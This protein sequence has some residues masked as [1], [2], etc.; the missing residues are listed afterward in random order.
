VGAA[1]GRC[2]DPVS[3]TAAGCGLSLGLSESE[4]PEVAVS[5]SCEGAGSLP[6]E[7]PPLLETAGA[8]AACQMRPPAREHEQGGGGRTIAAV[9]SFTAG[10]SSVLTMHIPPVHALEHGCS[11]QGRI[12]TPRTHLIHF[13]HATGMLQL[14][15][16]AAECS[17]NCGG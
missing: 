1:E 17:S 6:A 9:S 4:L 16:Y 12:Q 13:G 2:L 14:N 15:L 8:A 11:D 10:L 7:G 5:L 3:A